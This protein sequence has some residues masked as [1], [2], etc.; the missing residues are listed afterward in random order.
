MLLFAL[1]SSTLGAFAVV[2][3]IGDRASSSAADVDLPSAVRAVMTARY[4]GLSIFEP[5]RR[6][7]DGLW[8]LGGSV[9]ADGDVASG[10]Q[11]LLFLAQAVDGRWAVSLEG[12]P[13]FAAAASRAPAG[14]LGNAERV[15]L[16]ATADSDSGV[17]TGLQLP[18][19]A[20]DRWRHS[21]VHGNNGDNRPFNSI[22]FYDGDG[23]VRASGPGILYRFCTDAR[24]PF[25]KIVHPNGLGTSYYH[26][27]STTDKAD[28][29]Q[30]RA[31][32]YLGRIGASV[33]CGGVA[34]GNHVHWSLWRGDMP[35]PVHG[36][37]IGGWRWYEGSV[38]YQGFAERGQVRINRGQCCVANLGGD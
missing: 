7:P 38:A 2:V 23:R 33:P 13:E 21:G 28:G 34:R 1:A 9:L 5:K 22:D 35:V 32:E 24:W 10:P 3:P 17:E 27:Q 12:S 20:G 37:R 16:M 4:R 6:T 30:V 26:L 18:W 25:L 36:K 29:T 14:F 11:A 31:G 15:A 19:A 8:V